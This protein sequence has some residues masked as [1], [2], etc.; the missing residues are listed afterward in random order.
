MF[1]GIIEGIGKVKQVALSG[2]DMRL[3]ILSSFDLSDTKPGDSISV[4]GVCLTITDI[5]DRTFLADVS[6]ETLSRSALGR[7][8]IG[9]DVNLERALRPMDRLGGHIVTG[10]VDGVGEILNKEQVQ[11]SWRIRIRISKDLIRYVIEKGSIAVDG[12]S[13]TI[14]HCQNTFFEVNVIPETGRKTTLLRKKEGD[15]VNIETDVIG[16]YIERLI[17]Q[18]RI[19][20]KGPAPPVIDREMLRQYG[21]GD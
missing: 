18:E 12:I 3:S 8:K 4:N 6:G 11:R 10:H 16:K 15:P 14:N 20:E 5:H 19:S 2:Q 13:L 21:F 1:T 17:N 7:L 9:D